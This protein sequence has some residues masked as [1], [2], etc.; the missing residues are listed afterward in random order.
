MFTAAAL[1]S[2]AP[3]GR[4]A[5]TSAVGHFIKG[6]PVGYE[7]LGG[8]PDRGLGIIPLIVGLAAAGAQMY[9]SDQEAGAA[10]AMG[11]KSAEAMAEAQAAPFRY[12]YKTQKKLTEAARYELSVM[13]VSGQTTLQTEDNTGMYIAVALAGAVAFGAYFILKAV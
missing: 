13:A 6:G 12:A 11:I 9:A 1:A 8:G 2:M 5:A 7:A 4:Q 3:V 10:E